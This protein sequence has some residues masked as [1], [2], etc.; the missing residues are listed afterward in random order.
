MKILIVDDSLLVRNSVKRMFENLIKPQALFIAAKDGKAGLEMF[1]KEK[2][3]MMVIDLLMPVMDGEEV[4]QNIHKKKHNSFISVLSSNF[5]KPVRER[6]LNLGVNLFI[7]KPVT[8]EKA[9][10]IIKEY[11][12]WKE[13]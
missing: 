7:E 9:E 11:Y 10:M 3:D 6:M 5:Q 4:I 12:K 8:N 1:E 13:S 2:P